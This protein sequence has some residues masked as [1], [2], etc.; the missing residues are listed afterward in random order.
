MNADNITQLLSLWKAGHSRALNQ[1][2]EQ[3]YIDLLKIARSQMRGEFRGRTL[4]TEG[5]V[6]E[7]Y[8]RFHE[9][10]NI[11]WQDQSHFF[12]VAATV[13]RRVLIDRAR[14][15][16]AVKRDGA[17]TRITLDENFAESGI[18]TEIL[19][20]DEVLTRLSNREETLGS[21][22]ELRYFGGLTIAETARVLNLAPATVKRKWNLAQAWLYREMHSAV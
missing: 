6:H 11:A 2:I 19:E 5:L 17:A 20:L 12:R 14:A 15:R 4:E 9:L 3:A 1:L 16:N 8:L 18:F 22:V 10:K 21:I 7:A 13:M